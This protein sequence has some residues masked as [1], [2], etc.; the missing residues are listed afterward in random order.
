MYSNEFSR[1][2]SVFIAEKVVDVQFILSSATVAGV[3]GNTLR[4]IRR[5]QKIGNNPIG[6]VKSIFN[7]AQI[8]CSIVLVYGY[9]RHVF[10]NQV[11][12]QRSTS[13]ADKYTKKQYSGTR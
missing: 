1:L 8:V 2:P 7:G 6:R 4:F 3:I 10:P 13:N 11:S 5:Q 12:T 9:F